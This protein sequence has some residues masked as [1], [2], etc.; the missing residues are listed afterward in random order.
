MPQS[1]QAT[2]YNKIEKIIGKNAL[3]QHFTT[4]NEN[5]ITHADITKAKNL[6][7]YDPKVSF[8]QGIERFLDWHKQYEDI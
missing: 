7:G 5:I 2:C 8:D 1:K 4:E 6:L 3:I